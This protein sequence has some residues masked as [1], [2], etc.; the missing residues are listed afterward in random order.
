MLGRIENHVAKPLT[1]DEI[2]AMILREVALRVEVDE[3][4]KDRERL[5]WLADEHQTIDRIDR[6]GCN[7]CEGESLRDAIDQAMRE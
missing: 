3:L 4:R 1:K 7:W 2:E 5:D 6:V